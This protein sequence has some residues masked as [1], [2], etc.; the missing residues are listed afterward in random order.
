MSPE[1]ALENAYKGTKR[2]TFCFRQLAEH[3]RS[4]WG[5]EEYEDAYWGQLYPDYPLLE[6]KSNKAGDTLAGASKKRKLS[7]K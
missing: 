7:P 4:E 6:R 5:N 1:E 3:L 2:V